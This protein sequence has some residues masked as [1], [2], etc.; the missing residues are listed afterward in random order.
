MLKKGTV[1]SFFILDFISFFAL[2]N[3]KLKRPFEY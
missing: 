3:P 1:Q 2:F